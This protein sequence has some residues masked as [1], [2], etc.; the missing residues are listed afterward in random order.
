MSRLRVVTERFNFSTSTG[1]VDYTTT[2][3]EGATPD[4]AIIYTIGAT[5]ND[6]ARDN[7]MFNVAFLD[8]TNERI[9]G[10]FDEH[11][12]NPTVTRK[13]QRS[14]GV[15][16]AATDATSRFDSATFVSFIENGIRLNWTNAAAAGSENYFVVVFLE[17]P[18]LAEVEV[19]TITPGATNGSTA[20]ITSMSGEP[21]LVLF[22]STSSGASDQ[23]AG[24]ELQFSFGAAVNDGNETQR[25]TLYHSED[26][27][28]TV[29]GDGTCR[30]ETDAV[31]GQLSPALGWTGELT[32]FNSDGFTLTTRNGSTGGDI[33][34]YMA[35]RFA[36]NTKAWVD[37]YQ[38]QTTTGDQVIT[39]V[40]FKPALLIQSFT[41]CTNLNTTVSGVDLGTQGFSIA[42]EGNQFSNT[43]A[44]EAFGVPTNTQSLS[45]NILINYPDDDGD[46]RYKGTLVS[47]DNNGWTQNF[48]DT[49][50]GTRRW[51]AFAIGGADN[52]KTTT[53]RT[54]WHAS[55][56]TEK[57]TTSN[58]LQTHTSLTFTPNA[59]TDVAI[60]FSAQAKLST[61]SGDEIVTGLFKSTDATNDQTLGQPFARVGLNEVNEYMSFQGVRVESYGATPTEQT[62][63]VR[64]SNDNSGSTASCRNVTIFAIE[65]Q[66][67]DEYSTTTTAWPV[68]TT[69]S[70]S[71]VTV[72]QLQFTPASQGSYTTIFSGVIGDRGGTSNSHFMRAVQNTVNQTEMQ[73]ENDNTL[74]RH[75]YWEVGREADVTAQQTYE[76]QVRCET[77]SNSSYGKTTIVALRDDNL[78]EVFYDE[79]GID[80]TT[81]STTYQDFLTL[82]FTPDSFDPVVHIATFYTKQDS[83][84]NAVEARFLLDSA[85][86]EDPWRYDAQDATDDYPGGLL[87]YESQGFEGLTE[88]KNQF[89]RPSGQSGTAR[90]DGSGILVLNLGTPGTKNVAP[91]VESNTAQAIIAFNEEIQPGI[92]TDTSQALGVRI[93]ATVASTSPVAQKT[94]DIIIDK[95]AGTQQGDLLLAFTGS[96]GSDIVPPAGWTELGFD[97]NSGIRGEVHYKI[98]GASE[99]STYTFTCV[100][101]DCLGAIY[102]IIGSTTQDNVNAWISEGVNGTNPTCD[103]VT[104]TVDYTLVL[105]LA[106]KSNNNGF[107]APVGTIEDFY[108]TTS[109]SPGLTFGG[110]NEAGPTP[111]GDTGT[112]IWE[113]AVGTDDYVSF[114]IAIESRNI[115]KSQAIGLATE[116]NTAQALIPFNEEIGRAD[117]VD[118][119]QTVDRIA[120]AQFESVSTSVFALDGNALVI[121]KPSGTQEGDLLF[122]FIASDVS[123][124][125][126]SNADGFVQERIDNPDTLLASELWYKEAGAS[127]PATYTFTHTGSGGSVHGGNIYR[128][129]KAN[130]SDPFDVIGFDFVLAA[131][132]DPISPDVTTTTGRLVIRLCAVD[133]NDLD[134]G[135]PGYIEDFVDESTLGSDIAI[136]GAHRSKFDFGSTGTAEWVKFSS[137]IW[138]TYTVVIQEALVT[139]LDVPIGLAT[140]TD[141]SQALTIQATNDI[142]IDRAGSKAANGSR[143]DGTNDQL[144][145]S[146]DF[147]GNADSKLW[148]GSFWFYKENTDTERVISSTNGR[149]IV[150]Y[151]GDRIRIQGFNSAGTSILNI[152]TSADES[153]PN[154]W[155]HVMWSVDMANASNRHLYLDNASDLD[156][157]S[158]YTDDLI[159]FT[160]V[161]HSVGATPVG[162]GRWTGCFAEIWSGFGQYLDL[163]QAS[164][165]AK[166]YT[167]DGTA[168]D[169]GSD[170][171]TPT[172]TSPT[173][174]LAN[175]YTSFETNLGSGGDYVVTGALE[176]CVAP[177]KGL[178]SEVD[179]ALTITPSVG[180]AVEIGRADETDSA[181]AITL[182][183]GAVQ[184][185]IG[186][187]TETD[188]A[189]TLDI[190]T[191]IGRADETDTA[192]ALTAIAGELQTP[193]ALGTESDTA[194]LLDKALAIGLA[195][196]SDTAQ[197]IVLDAQTNVA[198]GQALETDFGQAISI[199]SVANV[200]IGR[201]DEVDSAQ[202]ILKSAG[203]SQDINPSTEADTSQALTIVAGAVQVAIGRADE[204]DS[205]LIAVATATQS[206][207]IGLTTE[208]D[209]A[210]VITPTTGAAAVSIV[211]AVE[212]DTAQTLSIT[213]A[214]TQADEV[215]TAQAL[216][217]SLATNVPIGRANEV[218]TAFIV[219]PLGGPTS[220]EIDTADEQDLSQALTG[221][222][223]TIPRVDTLTF[224]LALG[225]LTTAEVGVAQIKTAEQ[226]ATQVK[227]AEQ[228]IAQLKQADLRLE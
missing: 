136:G 111:A 54:F 193:I 179:L 166:F 97:S 204:T 45:D 17:G 68:G 88:L 70:T 75:S 31:C 143:F 135:P 74:D 207:P 225:Q 216:T 95:P 56:K 48:S 91:A 170:G 121:N 112:A 205:A 40:G 130:T 141:S 182:V 151:N 122:A 131:D 53:G 41:T 208:T 164:N 195:T 44:T 55:N 94:T 77:A 51:W 187:G 180:T 36:G 6:V 134:G 30:V 71:Y 109:G 81:T 163:S 165:R 226:T 73:R 217:T 57:S 21:D 168:A 221:S 160:E 5:T 4:A 33:A 210:L 15:V 28:P 213:F 20:S 211:Q 67:G 89:R 175:P 222:G 104:T 35:F 190:I 153:L 214:I 169:L 220:L 38:P 139:D 185:P 157:I 34:Y 24:T 32:S 200:D 37:D 76:L 99:P 113:N 158:D 3:L 92:E 27:Q 148:T 80:Q 150:S 119:A 87:F 117:E 60:I 84:N 171:S 177:N 96:T 154:G 39:G 100:S 12:A 133:D 61:A 173:I 22:T 124:R 188:S 218:D 176:D 186:L 138:Y 25:A 189:Q 98:A 183:V 58:T 196:E 156:S 52:I 125:D 2:A 224:G 64:W 201:S 120:G 26:N 206:E 146:S 47:F 162:T 114:T 29:G 78:K 202:I 137:D 144:T 23:D 14:D 85:E 42:A 194:Q 140:E 197:A 79:E 123:T 43:T 174:Y 59:N 108:D 90:A 103:P 93:G 227:T 8:G 86:V 101:L 178:R 132:P 102:R 82:N 212:V 107:T 13:M 69:S 19:G 127:E 161:S 115:D 159:D 9:A 192:Q 129:S 7:A 199:V 191:T 209:S 167:A 66:S 72:E 184:I 155:H 62:F 118:S 181:Q 10:G 172:G 11:N 142:D 128:I 145:R 228:K 203:N 198:I 106:V 65:L 147:S 116:T 152:A 18:D 1:N 63:E 110:A 223:G 46:V 215:D 149:Y 219:P 49:V 83:A 105:R 126:H 50:T 16:V